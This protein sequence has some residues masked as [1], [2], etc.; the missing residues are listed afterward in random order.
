M[1]IT[2]TIHAEG[3]HRK[4]LNITPTTTYEDLLHQLNINPETIILLHEDTPQPLDKT[5]TTE[6]EI[7]ILRI[8]SG[9]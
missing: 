3:T 8:T 6:G 7:K 4:T 1:E 9:G 2:I 5:I